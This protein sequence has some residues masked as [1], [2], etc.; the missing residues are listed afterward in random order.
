PPTWPAQITQSSLVSS[1]C[2][3]AHRI[4]IAS[5]SFSDCQSSTDAC[6]DQRVAQ[7]QT[8]VS[9]QPG[10]P[11]AARWSDVDR[12]REGAASQGTRY[13]AHLRGGG[14]HSTPRSRV[15]LAW[16]CSMNTLR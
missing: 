10:Y 14:C 6:R 9:T 1:P 2:T 11:P 4:F 3:S 16:R 13:D 8:F 15:A 12:D 7:G 5:G